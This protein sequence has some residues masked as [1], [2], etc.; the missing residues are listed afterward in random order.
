MNISIKARLLTDTLTAEYELPDGASA[1]QAID[2]LACGHPEA[3][4]LTNILIM[5]NGRRAGLSTELSDGDRLDV[6][7][8]LGGG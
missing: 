5:V 6:I 7:Q 2:L 8:I 4:E 1:G 3:G